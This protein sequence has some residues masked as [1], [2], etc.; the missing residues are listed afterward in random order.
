M[1]VQRPS[2]VMN[3]KLKFDET[4]TVTPEPPP[5]SVEDRLRNPTPPSGGATPQPLITQLGDENVSFILQRV[6][7]Q[8][9]MEK[10]G[11]R[12]AGKWSATFP[13]NDL[14]IDPRTVAAASVE[15]HIGVISDADFAKGME[16]RNQDGSLSS[17]LQTRTDRKS[18]V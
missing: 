6:P 16:K 18:V 10:P 12:Q 5:E 9:S 3:F 13:F 1:T 11:Y 2:W 15:I 17:V 8:A 7:I 14:P 4:L